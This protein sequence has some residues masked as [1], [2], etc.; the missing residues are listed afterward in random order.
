M[1]GRVDDY[2]R[3]LVRITLR[4]PPT[5]VTLDCEAWVDTAFTGELML[6]D[7]ELVG[8]GLPQV[9]TAVGTLGDGSQATFKRYSCRI[10]WFGA[11]LPAVALTA[12]GQFPLVGVGLLA[13]HV[14]VVDYPR[15]TVAIS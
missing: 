3:A 8:L 15:R 9:G 12:V 14:L 1:T 11:D 10:D 13:D 4:N 5:G 6:R 7:A 2:G